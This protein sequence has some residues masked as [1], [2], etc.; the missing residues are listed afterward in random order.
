M[1]DEAK[2]R[3]YSEDFQKELAALLNNYGIDAYLGTEDYALAM[4]ICDFLDFQETA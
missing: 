4:K 3:I 1:N 2:N